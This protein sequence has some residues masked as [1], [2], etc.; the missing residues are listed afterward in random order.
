MTLRDMV[1]VYKIYDSPH[2]PLALVLYNIICNIL[3]YGIQNMQD[4]DL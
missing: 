2:I 3:L 1:A 4:N